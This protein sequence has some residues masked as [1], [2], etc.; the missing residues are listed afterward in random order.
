MK[1]KWINLLL[2]SL[3]SF[4]VA[5]QTTGYTYFCIPDTV[6]QS[7]FYKIELT[8][9]INAHVNTAYSDIRIVNKEDKWVPHVVITPAQIRIN[10][11]VIMDLNFSIRENN[12]VNTTILVESP[13]RDISNIGLVIKN[14]AAKRFCTLSGSDD[15]HNWFVIND[16]IVLG[17]AF[18]EDATDGILRIDFPSSNYKYFR[19]IIYNNHKDPFHINNVVHYTLAAPIKFPENKIT[20]NPTTIINQRDSGKISYI[21]VRQ[22]QGYHFNNMSLRLA[23][24]KYFY[25]KAAL[26][27]ADTSG[28]FLSNTG[29]LLQSFTI[30][31]NSTLQFRTPLSNAPAFYIVIENG[32]NLPL[33]VKEVTTS[34]EETFL[35]A[36]L[37]KG[38]AYKLIMG[39]P[40]A[41]KP[42]YDISLLNSAVILDSAVL[43]SAKN[44]T[45]FTHEL[46][47]VTA[48]KSNKWMLWSVT[49][50]V[51]FILLFLTQKMI[52]EVDKTT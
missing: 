36:Y 43:L 9:E 37:E 27:V 24:P 19:I 48:V 23:G 33:T 25:R 46:P 30:S 21:L 18:E 38:E 35:A 6:K 51:L 2:I 52:R 10:E 14:T 47:A 45:A 49:A 5:A 13:K 41:E 50:A 39:N 26:Y 40:L 20:Q 7:G 17:T 8:P 28:R 4:S 3:L 12:P 42:A 22:Q 29:K 16:S 1:A 11:T 32:D 34:N 44:V 31:N 15:Q